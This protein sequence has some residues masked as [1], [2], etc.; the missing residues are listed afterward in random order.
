MQN[1][2]HSIFTIISLTEELESSSETHATAIRE[3]RHKILKELEKFC[4]DV[5][6]MP[7][8]KLIPNATSGMSKVFF[9]KT[10]GD[11]NRYLAECG[12]GEKRN[13]AITSAREADNTATDIA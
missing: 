12:L 10:K 8:E 1:S 5:L 4:E 13:G 7:D 9:Y 11:Y 2:Y 6:K 3:F